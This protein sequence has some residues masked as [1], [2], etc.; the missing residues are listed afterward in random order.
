MA[1]IEMIHPDKATGL[2]KQVY[3]FAIQRAGKVFNVLRVMSLNPETLKASMELYLATMYAP[4]KLSRA[5]REMI[6]TVVS[7]ENNCYY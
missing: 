5:Q 2:L 4:S 7:R 3:D 6:A 1:F